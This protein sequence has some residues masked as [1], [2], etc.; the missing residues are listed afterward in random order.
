[1][2]FMVQTTHRRAPSSLCVADAEP[3]WL[4][5]AESTDAAR[6]VIA[7]CEEAAKAVRE[8]GGTSYD[9]TSTRWE[10]GRVLAH[11]GGK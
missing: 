5:E 11:G 3:W 1:M 10:F 9:P 8:A 6:K 4:V 2:W 7:A